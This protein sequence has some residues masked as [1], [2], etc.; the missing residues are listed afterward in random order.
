[1]HFEEIDHVRTIIEMIMN[2]PKKFHEL[3]YMNFK[4]VS[5]IVYPSTIDLGGE[6]YCGIIIGSSKKYQLSPVAN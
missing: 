6:Y 3:V 4:K 2:F 1:M 5:I